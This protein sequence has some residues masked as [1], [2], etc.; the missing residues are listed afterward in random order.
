MCGIG[1]S[2]PQRDRLHKPAL[3]QAAVQLGQGNDDKTGIKAI[4]L[5]TSP[6]FRLGL[7]ESRA[8]GRIEF[9]IP[10]PG[11]G[12]CSCVALTPASMQSTRF[13]AGMTI[14]VYK[15]MD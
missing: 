6:S 10:G 12:S 8:Q 15:G 7:P 4:S 5:Y 13:P 11:F 9:A 1:I 14:F 3:Q 2:S